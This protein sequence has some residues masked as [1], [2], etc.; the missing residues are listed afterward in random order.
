M[1]WARRRRQQEQARRDREVARARQAWAAQLESPEQVQAFLG[2]VIRAVWDR[3][4]AAED[5]QVCLDG[6]RLLARLLGREGAG[7]G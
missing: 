4:M 1:A 2:H 6:A 7:R 5:A 3:R